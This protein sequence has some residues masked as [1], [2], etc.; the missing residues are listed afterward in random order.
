MKSRKKGTKKN[1][2]E[3]KIPLTVW[4]VYLVVIKC[5]QLFGAQHGEVSAHYTLSDPDTIGQSEI[6]QKIGL[7]TGY[8]AIVSYRYNED[9]DGNCKERL[10][11]RSRPMIPMAAVDY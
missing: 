4:K 1:K 7:L 5:I 6:C 3:Q 10:V 8:Y 9:V 11:I 2:K